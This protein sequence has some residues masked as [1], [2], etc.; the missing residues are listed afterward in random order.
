MLVSRTRDAEEGWK[1]R[2]GVYSD[3]GL[4]LGGSGGGW[5]GL[6]GDSLVIVPLKVEWG[7]WCAK[8]LA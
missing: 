6:D 5:K 8:G 1:G 2:L 7:S 4:E 3:R